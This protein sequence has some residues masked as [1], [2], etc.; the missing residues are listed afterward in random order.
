ML[1][2]TQTEGFVSVIQLIQHMQINVS[3]ILQSSAASPTDSFGLLV[4]SLPQLAVEIIES[5]LAGTFVPLAV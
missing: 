4:L 3:I 5:K 1:G 2:K